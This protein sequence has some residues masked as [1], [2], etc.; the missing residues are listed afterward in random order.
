GNAGLNFVGGDVEEAVVHQPVARHAKN[1]A[2][3]QYEIDD[4]LRLGSVGRW[5]RFLWHRQRLGFKDVGRRVVRIREIVPERGR[6]ILDRRHKQ[7]ARTV[8]RKVVAAVPGTV[9]S[10]RSERAKAEGREIDGRQKAVLKEAVENARRAKTERRETEWPQE[11]EEYGRPETKAVI[12][13]IAVAI[14]HAAAK[15]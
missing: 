12:V 6:Q 11:A 4:W 1:R 5:R 3:F 2:V 10:E 15:P 7:K 9:K 13:E 8:R 14:Q